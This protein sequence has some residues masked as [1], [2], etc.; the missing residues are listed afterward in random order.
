MSHSK[1]QHPFS[2]RRSNAI[3]K[4]L[5]PF[6]TGQYC[7]AH[8]KILL[9]DAYPCPECIV[10]AWTPIVR[11]AVYIDK[12]A[13]SQACMRANVPSECLDLPPGM[14]VGADEEEYL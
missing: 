9:N 8:K 7:V 1:K 2:Q 5:R 11:A 14:G 4:Y 12:Q 6:G 10:E 13:W 3:K